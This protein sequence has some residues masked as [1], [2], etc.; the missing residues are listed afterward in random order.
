MEK[1]KGWFNR[2]LAKGKNR[3]VNLF[4]GHSLV[5]AYFTVQ[6]VKISLVKLHSTLDNHRKGKWADDLFHTITFCDRKFCIKL[7]KKNSYH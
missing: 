5:T 4:S 1:K 7:E 6:K 3:T 2:D